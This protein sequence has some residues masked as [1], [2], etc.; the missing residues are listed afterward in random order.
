MILL[1]NMRRARCGGCGCSS[2]FGSFSKQQQSLYPKKECRVLLRVPNDVCSHRPSKVLQMLKS[3]TETPSSDSSAQ[4]SRAYLAVKVERDR[5]NGC[6]IKANIQF[7]S[8]GGSKDSSVYATC[9][10]RYP[11]LETRKTHKSPAGLNSRKRRFPEYPPLC[12]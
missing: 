4:L 3:L 7:F 12:Q 5:G 6:S 1:V 2:T 9:Y 10:R 8:P 11:V